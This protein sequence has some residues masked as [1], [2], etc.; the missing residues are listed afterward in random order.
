MAEMRGKVR[1]PIRAYRS[2]LWLVR[3]LLPWSLEKRRSLLNAIRLRPR[4][5]HRQRSAKL[6]V[7]L[8][9]V[10]LLSARPEEPSARLRRAHKSISG[11]GLRECSVAI[12]SNYGINIEYENSSAGA[13]A[14]DFF[15]S[16]PW[17]SNEAAQGKIN[18]FMIAYRGLA[19]SN[20]TAATS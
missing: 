13:N 1:R 14:N 8:E 4:N 5:I 7:R 11:R 18:D 17:A 9:I 20:G 2:A 16:S 10:R 12:R 3:S 6:P 19:A 15:K